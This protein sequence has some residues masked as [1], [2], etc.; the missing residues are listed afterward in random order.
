MLVILNEVKDVLSGLLIPIKAKD[1]APL[2]SHR[3]TGYP[4]FATPLSLSLRW[5][6]LYR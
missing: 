2:P 5:D 6:T 3:K 4:T 1:P